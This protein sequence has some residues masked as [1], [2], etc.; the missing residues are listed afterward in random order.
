MALYFTPA[1]L[2]Y[3]AQAILA[4]LIAG[5]FI[6]RLLPRRADR[7]AHRVLL[8]GF[9]VCIALLTRLLILEAALPP[10][11]R[12]YAVILQAPVLFLG[13]ILLQQFAY[14]FPQP[15]PH[16]WEARL[17]LVLSLAYLLFEAGYAIYRFY[18]LSAWGHVIYRPPWAD[19]P[20]ALGL[21]WAPVVLL[22]Q[23]AR[24]SKQ[25]PTGLGNLSGLYRL[26]H[27]QDPAA[28]AARAMALI[29]LAVFGVSLLNILRPF[30]YLPPQPFQ[31]ASRLTCMGFFCI[32]DN[33]WQLT[34]DRRS[35]QTPAV[36]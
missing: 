10:S 23:A 8:T 4:L 34:L 29:Y 9:F 32:L 1:A 22:R 12:W 3:L 26:W 25:D 6:A 35:G 19:Y 36:R 30:S 24:A 18:L 17:V 16:K 2:G 15:F 28:R 5:Y 27:P 11:E 20:M 21:L 7:P 13:I 31:L 33:I 14:R